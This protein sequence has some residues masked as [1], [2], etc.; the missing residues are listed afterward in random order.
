MPGCRQRSG[1]QSRSGLS[2]IPPARRYCRAKSTMRAAVAV[3]VSLRLLVAEAPRKSEPQGS[4]PLPKLSVPA[5]LG[6]SDWL[7]EV[8]TKLFKEV[9]AAPAA[10]ELSCWVK[11]LVAA[12]SYK[13]WPAV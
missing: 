2:S 12:H 6:M 5:A 7:M 3:P 8:A 10:P 13:F 9:E 4:A 1:W 11:M